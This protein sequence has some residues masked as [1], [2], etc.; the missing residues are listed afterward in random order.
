MNLLMENPQANNLITLRNRQTLDIEG[1]T[2]LDSFDSKEFMM[3]TNM[4]YLC[5]TGIDLALGHMNLDKGMLSIKGTIDSVKF[6][7]K[8]KANVIKESFLSKLFK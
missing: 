2:K 6:T 4:G 3:D 1:V 8:N 7:S 5:V